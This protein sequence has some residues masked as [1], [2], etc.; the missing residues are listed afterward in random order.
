MAG[1]GGLGKPHQPPGNFRPRQMLCFEIFGK[2]ACRAL[3][4]A[5]K[6]G[7]RVRGPMGDGAEVMAFPGLL[8]WEET[9]AEGSSS[10]SPSELRISKKKGAWPGR[11]R[12]WHR[13]SG[14]RCLLVLEGKDAH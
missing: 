11:R 9:R 4:H 6:Y 14:S 1:C 2:N 13:M 10:L 5:C 7:G 8:C 12:T 3:I